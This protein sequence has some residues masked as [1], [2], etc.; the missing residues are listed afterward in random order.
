MAKDLELA[1]RI[2]A[3]L[4][5]AQ[6]ALRQFETTLGNTGNSAKRASAGLAS[7]GTAVSKVRS[8]I[9]Q[10]PAMLT[11]LAGLFAAAFSV[12]EIAQATQAYTT[13][14][15]RL[16][17]V[18]SSS[19]ELAQAQDAVFQAAQNARQPLTETAELYQ[20]IATNA[21]ELGLSAAGVSGVVD[22][23]SKSLAIS[24]TSGQAASA[25]LTQLGQAF[26]SGTLRGEELNSVM[27]QAPALAKTLAA[28]LGVSI[29]QL[30]QLG[31]DGQLS[32]QNVIQALQTQAGAVDQQFGKIQITGEQAMTVLGNSLTRVVGELDQ[33]TGASSGFANMIQQISQWLDS[34]QLTNGLLDSLSIWSGVFE[35]MSADVQGLELDMQGVSAAGDETSKFLL[36]AFK[37]MPVNLRSAIQL[38]TTE[39]LSL[40]DR[41]VVMA[42]FMEE[43]TASAFNSTTWDDAVRKTNERLAQLNATRDQSIAAI[44]DE[45]DAILGAA[46]A[47]RQRREQERKA[48]DEARVQREKDIAELRKQA[49]DKGVTFAPGGAG[50]TGGD[51]AAKDAER[52]VAQL[53]RQSSA[54]GKNASEVRAYELAE[55]G[56]TGTLLARAQ[57][58]LTVLD[59]EERKRQSD[60]DSKQL[61]GIQAQLLAAQG[62]QAEATALQL[63][64]QYGELMQ[65]LQASGDQAGQAL[66]HKLINVEQAKA[67]LSELQAQVDRVF[68][69]QARQESSIQTQQQAGLLSELGARQQIIDLHAA[70]ASEVEKLLPQMQQLAAVTGDPAAIER[71]KDLQAQLEQTRDSANDLANAFTSG[72]QDGLQGA[73][74]G[75]AT[76]TLNLQ[77][78]ATAFVDGIAASMASLAAQQLSQMATD[79]LS[80]LLG[81]GG[82]SGAGLVVGAAAVD[83]SAIALTG[84]GSTLLAG[85]AAL[86]AAAVSL[87]AANATAG[88]GGGSGGSGDSDYFGLAM[89]V[90]SAWSGGSGGG[91][92][93]LAT[94]GQVL[95]PGTG[96]SDSIPAW[97]SN[98]EFVTRAAVVT[99]PGALSFLHD[100]NA[101]GMAALDDHAWRVRHATGGLAGVPAPAF[102]A[103]GLGSGQFDGAGKGN[104][105]TVKNA[106]NLYAVQDPAAVAGMAWGK[107]GQEHFMVYLQQNGAQVRQ[108]LGI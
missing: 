108:L 63:E 61:T 37:E 51:K 42:R 43:A 38:A 84:A 96:T 7:T 104:G 12:R 13:I 15:N 46:A 5:Q 64:Q 100:F 28:G 82:D 106:V 93:T 74:E 49:G 26:A 35:A 69:E 68:A 10:L 73:L 85:A 22:T 33:A 55:K 97:L 89:A 81:G 88:I 67:Q 45:R 44:V 98:T 58:A 4:K 99:Q 8:E 107:A 95:G 94:G 31:A 77:E 62:Q 90:F 23:I 105:T 1:L 27:E 78:A 11:R 70:T 20:R 29:G 21:D 56:L 60:A 34:G 91:A 3:D 65:R 39:I 75:L 71:V 30:R 103:P 48:R 16:A 76:G 92:K 36:Q 101:R 66:I 32:A 24:G 14:R 87:A 79:S 6:A 86:E 47:D 9:G 25:A 102:P 50:N 2:K 54:I 80:G 72:L 57:A 83:A 41:V 18:T 52:Y 19:E 40:F 53:E 17:L 59:A